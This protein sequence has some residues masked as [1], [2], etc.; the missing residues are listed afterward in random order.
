MLMAAFYCFL[1]LAIAKSESKLSYAVNHR[2]VY[3]VWCYFAVLVFYFSFFY[4]YILWSYRFAFSFRV[5]VCVCV[6]NN[7]KNTLD[8]CRCRC[9]RSY[10]CNLMETPTIDTLIDLN[11]MTVNLDIVPHFTYLFENRFKNQLIPIRF[12]N[13]KNECDSFF[14]NLFFCSHSPFNRKYI[15]IVSSPQSINFIRENTQSNE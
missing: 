7:S 13:W 2:I 5:F 15:C 3:D 6:H 1:F 4:T 8:L 11:L 9:F 12:T 14:S 10:T